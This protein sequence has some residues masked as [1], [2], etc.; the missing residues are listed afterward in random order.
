MTVPRFQNLPGP[1]NPFQAL[2]TQEDSEFHQYHRHLD[3]VN[4]GLEVQNRG[5]VRA[6][7]AM[8][9]RNMIQPEKNEHERLGDR[10]VMVNY[11]FVRLLLP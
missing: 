2:I 9:L 5:L 3:L 1:E 6:L 11:D 7:L 8:N 10:N 4:P